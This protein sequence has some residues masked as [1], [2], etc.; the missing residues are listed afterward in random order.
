MNATSFNNQREATPKRNVHPMDATGQILT[1]IACGMLTSCPDSYEN[2][3]SCKAVTEAA[4]I[5]LQ[6]T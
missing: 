4:P 3:A 2:L 5:L 1:C 6:A